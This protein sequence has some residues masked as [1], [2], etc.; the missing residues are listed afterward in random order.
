MVYQEQ[1]M[2]ILNRL[3]KIPLGNSYSCIK[4]I[5]KKKEEQI[6]K[7]RAQFINGAHENG[8]TKDK[9][10][11]IFELII[12][13]AGYGFNK[14]HSTAYALI[15]YMTAYLKA[16]YPVE[17]MAAL[18][19]GDVSKRN[20]KEK[21]STVEHI[22]DCRRMGITVIPPDVN[23]SKQLYSVTDGK[24][25]FALTAIKGCKDWAADKIVIARDKGGRFRSLFDFCE[26]V[27]NR[28]CSRG[29]VEF[30]IKAGAF[31][32][33]GSHR[34]QLFR[35]LEQAFKSAQS[36]AEDKA[37]GQSTFFSKFEDDE[38]E[39]VIAKP[40]VLA[41][42]PDI[43]EWSDKEKA[44][45][46]KEVLGFYLSSHPL[47]D[48]ELIFEQI[49]SHNCFEASGLPDRTDVILAG[50]VNDIK[51]S[52][53]KN[54]KQGR[55]NQ[56]AMFTLEDTDGQIRSI[57]W[58][59]QYAQ[60]SHLIKSESIVF[61][62]GRTDRT[63][64]QS[65]NDGNFIVDEMY[66]VEEAVEKLS[67]GLGITLDEQ[68]H[69][70]ESVKKLYEILRGYPGQGTLEFSVQLR[71]GSLAQLR[72]PK[73]RVAIR[74]EMQQRVVELLGNDAIRLLKVIP[75]SRESRN[76]NQKQWKRNT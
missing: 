76:G 14:S 15:A 63:R 25:T 46:E 21:D 17:F 9:A 12:K 40:A 2:R 70:V 31:D 54:T 34:S 59:E 8:L 51:V 24:I 61:A 74:S 49:R 1:I 67:R 22:E 37:K 58:P 32:S 71:N 43:E 56:F 66:T 18:L 47:K 30:L 75:K 68:R 39:V 42:L 11:E 6:G 5:S 28:A 65:D 27:D 60:C 41:A 29:T 48:Y 7:Y 62:V 3:G 72:N 69:S 36:T 4:A 10:E 20:L 38:P 45:F 26:R 55:P 64:S 73:L 35:I 23:T 33:L 19:C 16:H 13:F 53:T 57:V 50:V 44:I 52:S